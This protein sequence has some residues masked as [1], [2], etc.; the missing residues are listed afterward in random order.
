VNNK[1]EARIARSVEREAKRQQKSARLVER[2]LNDLPPP[3][4]PR[5]GANPNSIYQLLMEWS[6]DEAD[7]EGDWSWGSRTWAA[8]AWDGIILP[9]LSSF[10]T[11]RWHEVEAAK[12]DSGHKMHHAMP[13]E[14]ICD[15]CQ[16][17]LLELEKL[18][19][20][21]YRLRLGNRRRLLGI[22]RSAS[23]RDHLL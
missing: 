6:A 8:E 3:R 15:E 22:S 10:E 16:T 23:V 7:H 13:I 21:I 9:K 14:T 20:D 19:G 5:L 18:D 4:T 11:M 1:R 2:I 12:T 17:R